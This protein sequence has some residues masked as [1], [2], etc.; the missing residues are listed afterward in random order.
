VNKRQLIAAAARRSSLTQG[1]VRGAL[2]AIQEVIARAL[3]NG[4]HVTIS[5]FGRFDVQQY[6]GRKLRRFDGEG[7]F[8][9]KDRRVPVFRSS[10]L[11]RQRLRRN[12]S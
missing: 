8:E 9:V 1:Q 4:D 6:A 2:E 12:N 11:L 10:K 3:A 5:G 7:H